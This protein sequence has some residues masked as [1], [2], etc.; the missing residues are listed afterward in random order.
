M[1]RTQRYTP[2]V[3]DDEELLTTSIV[4]LASEYGW[5]GYRRITALLRG[6][7]WRVNH[8]RVERIWRQEGLKVPGRQP[9]RGRL[10]LNDGSC[11]RLRPEHG[12]H[13]WAYDFIFDRTQEGRPLKLLTGVD[14]FTRECLAIEVARKQSSRDVLR[15]LAG[16]ML[17]H[18]IPKHIRSDN[19]S[20]F[21]AKAVRE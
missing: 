2:R 10:W 8:K 19:R 17:R 20:E 11:I 1:R 13:V 14:E 16:L 5:Y 18:G 7:G 15:M 6:D 12:N 4:F 21:V 9:K 3:P